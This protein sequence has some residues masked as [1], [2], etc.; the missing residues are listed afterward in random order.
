MPYK[1]NSQKNVCVYVSMLFSYSAVSDSGTSWT[2]A[3]T[4]S[5]VHVISQARILEWVAISFSSM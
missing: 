1:I 5:S 2:V 4:G 3:L